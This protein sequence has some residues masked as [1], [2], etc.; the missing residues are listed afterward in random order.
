MMNLLS[1][2]RK[3]GAVERCSACPGRQWPSLR[4]VHCARSLKSSNYESLCWLESTNFPG[5]RFAVRKASLLQRLE[6]SK[7]IQELT[8]KHEFLAAGGISEQ[9]EATYADLLV[10]ELYLECGTRDG[11]GTPD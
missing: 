8:L 3:S 10:R 11:R 4:A 5:V 1:R 2:F 9:L 7:R 6:L